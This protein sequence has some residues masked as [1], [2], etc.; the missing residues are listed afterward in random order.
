MIALAQLAARVAAWLAANWKMISVGASVQQVLALM[1]DSGIIAWLREWVVSDAAERAGLHLDKEDPL[2]DASLANALGEKIGFKLRSLK[3]KDI[4]Q[5]DL[6]NGAA[7]LVSQRTGIMIRTLT[8]REMMIEDLENF[9]LQTIEGRSGIHLSSLRDVEKLKLDFLRIAGGVVVEQTGIPLTDISSPDQIK[10]DL[11]DWAKDQAMLEI[12]ESVST[13]VTA[14]WKQ[15]VTMLQMVRDKLGKKVSP[16]ALLRG[17]NDAMV[18]RYMIKLDQPANKQITK[19]DHKRYLNKMNQRRFRARG[20][21]NNP[22]WD[23]RTGAKVAYVRVGR[24]S[25]EILEKLR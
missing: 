18:S 4:L 15:G 13:A 10:L 8:D 12:G 17:V 24:D 23:G 2:S 3:D 14:Q 20:D 6:L 21:R 16:K 9:A 7:A 25:C 5:A 22:L 11:M 19:D 1:M